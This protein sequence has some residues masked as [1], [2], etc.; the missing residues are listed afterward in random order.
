NATMSG[1]TWGTVVVEASETSGALIQARKCL[2]QGRKLFIPRS[3]L[4]NRQITWPGRFQ[5]QGARVFGTIDELLGAFEA[6]GL[7]PG[8]TTGGLRPGEVVKLNVP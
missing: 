6:D 4:E 8:E 7:L 1:L 3:A 2:A 5:R